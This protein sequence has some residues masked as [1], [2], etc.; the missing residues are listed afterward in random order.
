MTPIAQM[1]SKLIFD[2]N[3]DKRSANSNLLCLTMLNSLKPQWKFLLN[4]NALL[5]DEP[6]IDMYP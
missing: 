4:Y 5:Y 1:P 6:L 2:K 3:D